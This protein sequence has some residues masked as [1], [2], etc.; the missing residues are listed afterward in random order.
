MRSTHR[1]L[2]LVA[3]AALA[4]AF[5]SPLAAKD[6]PAPAVANYLESLEVAPGVEHRL[7]VLYPVLARPKPLKGDEAF[8][9]AGAA[10]PDLVAVGRISP[11]AKTHAEAVSLAP[12]PMLVLEGDVL[13]TPTSDQVV[14]GDALLHRGKPGELPVTRVSHEVDEDAAV[15]ETVFMGEVL[16]SPLRHL[17]MT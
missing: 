11:A 2:L 13:R 16:P 17:V 12:E 3:G 15:A 1:T 6:D 9:L 10:S 8:R 7:V 14:T 4:A 5:P